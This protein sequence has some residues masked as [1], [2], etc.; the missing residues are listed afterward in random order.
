MVYSYVL[1]FLVWA[2]CCISVAF[3]HLDPESAW[4]LHC[5]CNQESQIRVDAGEAALTAYAFWDLNKLLY[6]MVLGRLEGVHNGAPNNSRH[7]GAPTRRSNFLKYNENVEAQLDHGH[8]K[9]SRS[10]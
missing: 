10:S 2:E 4:S 9:Y 6:G 1:T 5:H 8:V 3:A 7:E